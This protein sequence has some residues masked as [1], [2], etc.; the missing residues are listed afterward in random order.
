[1]IKFLL[2]YLV[3]IVSLIYLIIKLSIKKLQRDKR[4]LEDTVRERTSEM[5][6][7]NQE[8][9]QQNEEIQ[10]QAEEL[11]TANEHLVH[12]EFAQAKQAVA[13]A[14]SVVNKNKI[15]L[16]EELYRQNYGQLSLMNDQISDAEKASLDAAKIKAAGDAADLQKSIR[17]QVE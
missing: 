5:Q 10:A 7:Q 15:L 6:L 2:I 8:I 16:G 13:K 4:H 1:M 11:Y 14:F 17:D 3:I 12:D 9:Q